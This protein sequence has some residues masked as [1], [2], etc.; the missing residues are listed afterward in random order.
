M[1]TFLRGKLV[2]ALPTQ[3]VVEVHGVGYE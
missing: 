1:I 3:A 2:E